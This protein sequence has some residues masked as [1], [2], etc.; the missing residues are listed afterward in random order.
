MP[1]NVDSIARNGDASL[2]IYDY[3][4]SWGDRPRF[5]GCFYLVAL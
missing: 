2:F 5:G 4:E 1:G 3:Y